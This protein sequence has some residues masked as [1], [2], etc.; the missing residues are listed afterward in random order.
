METLI[1]SKPKHDLDSVREELYQRAV[2]A[3]GYE[4]YFDWVRRYWTSRGKPLDFK[5]HSY[6]L[7]FYKDQSD[8]IITM[9]SVQTGATERLVTEALWL[10][11][12]FKENA[13][14]LFPTS[15]TLSDLVQERVRV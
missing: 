10:P 5:D 2:D 6:L 11:D 7:D 4:A 13:I 8:E 1:E 12:Q 3:R 14:Y 9:K 15:G